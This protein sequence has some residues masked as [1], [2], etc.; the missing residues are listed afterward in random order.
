MVLSLTLVTLVAAGILGSIYTL[1]K[2]PIEKAETE[3]TQK[4]ITAVLPQLEGMRL[5]EGKS[6]GNLTVHTAYVGE[7][8]AGYAVEADTRENK[9]KPFGGNFKLM[10]GFDPDGS[11]IQY[12]VINQQE[13]P[14][15]GAK[16]TNWFNEKDKPARC[17]LGREIALKP[18]AVTKDGGDVDAITAATITSRAF[19][20]VIQNAHDI[21]FARPMTGETEETNVIQEASEQDEAL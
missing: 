19:L 14:G 8:L 1:T 5:D 2:E 9:N 13:T 18:L 10:I 12:S 21:L 16:M 20:E 3:K 4:A 15:L 17:I 7:E 6:I 11:V